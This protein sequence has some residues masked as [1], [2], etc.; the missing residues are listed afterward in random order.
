MVRI[1]IECEHYFFPP[2]IANTNRMRIQL[3]LYKKGKKSQNVTTDANMTMLQWNKFVLQRNSLSV[4]YN[5][6]STE[7][8]KANSDICSIITLRFD[9]SG[10]SALYQHSISFIVKTTTQLQ[11]QASSIWKFCWLL[12]VLLMW[13]WLSHY[14]TIPFCGY[15]QRFRFALFWCYSN[16][17]LKQPQRRSESSS[18]QQYKHM[19]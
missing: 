9:C 1:S 16:S 17:M 8:Q 18:L 5:D 15:F 10:C 3:K 19:D 2:K 14:K 11:C 6:S 7:Q 4:C 12:P 13:T